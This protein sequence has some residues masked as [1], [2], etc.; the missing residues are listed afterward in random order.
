METDSLPRDAAFDVARRYVRVNRWRNDGFVE[1]E[2]AVGDADLRVELILPRESFE[3]FRS[4]PGIET[5]SDDA[6]AQARARE[7]AYLYGH[8]DG[9]LTTK[10]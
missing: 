8:C 7:Q 5:L 6:V 9:V 2:L 1:F 3:V 10:P 4:R